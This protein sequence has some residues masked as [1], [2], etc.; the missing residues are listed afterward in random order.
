MSIRPAATDHRPF[1]WRDFTAPRHWPTWLG[2]AALRLLAALP[3]DGAL[4]FGRRIGPFVVRALPS[5]ARIA[6]TNLALAFPALDAPARERL[7][8]RNFRQLGMAFAETAWQWFRPAAGY[9]DRFTLEGAE[10]LDAALARGRGVVLLQAH[11]TLID[12]SAHTMCTRWPIACV[13]DPPKNAL[14]GLLQ[15]RQRERWMVQTIPNRDIRAMVR[16]LRDGGIVW[17]SPDQSV[18]AARGGVATRYFGVP[19]STSSGTARMIAMTGAALV[20]MIPVRSDDG[21]RYTLRVLPAVD[22]DTS[23]TVAA[24]QAIN[25]LLEAQVRAHPEQYLWVHRRF[26]PP[27]RSSPDRYA[28]PDGPR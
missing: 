28:R 11:F 18:S 13:Y 21:R 10:H 5:R 1:P 9:R 22:I 26:K 14:Y 2:L 19:V 20:P 6:D 15:R 23:D 17:F 4:A 8:T 24:T 16:R 27:D 7:A 25:D 12:L 3:F